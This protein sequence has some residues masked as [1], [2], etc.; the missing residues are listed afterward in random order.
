MQTM[1]KGGNPSI[2]LATFAGGCF[3]CLEEAFRQQKGVQDVHSGYMGGAKKTATY[4]QVCS[5]MTKHLEVIQLKFNKKIISYKELLDFFWLQID[6]TD[7]KGQF[8]DRGN[9][10]KTAIFYHDELQKEIAIEFKDNLQNSDLFIDKEIATK[11]L[12]ASTFYISEEHHQNFFQKNP[13]HYRNYYK[14]SKK[15]EIL[16]RV[17][18]KKNS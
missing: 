5:G 7:F 12:K 2:K 4:E 8:F 17:W 15:K 13:L 3:W 16:S 14:D 9:Q 18:N 11:I 1:S 10:Y 6:P